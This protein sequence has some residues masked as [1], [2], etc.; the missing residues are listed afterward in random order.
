MKEYIVF[1]DLETTGIDRDANNIRIVEITAI[2]VNKDNLEEID[3]LYYKCNND[4]VKIAPDAIKK[5]H[6]TEDDVKDCP[7]FQEVANN[8]YKFF[9]GCDVGGYNCTN[10]DNLVLYMSFIRA[11]LNWD[12]R[13]LNVYDIF[14]LYKKFNSGKLADVYK[15]YTGKELMDAHESTTDIIA[16]LDIYK[17]QRKLGEEFEENE[18]PV[19]ESHLDIAGNFKIRLNERGAKEVY[20]DFG[21]W[22]GKSIDQIDKNYFA[23]MM[24]SADTFPLDTR[25]YAKKIYE[26]KGGE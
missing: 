10:Y 6:I 5:H 8:V 19:Y 3:R 23:W 17:Q 22:K 9:E 25:H 12:Y 1:Y 21:K 7:T 16:T 20:I 11:G 13:S 26:R 18:L 14:T 24:K 15:K 4:G 2:K